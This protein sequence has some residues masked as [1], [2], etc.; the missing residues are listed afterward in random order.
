RQ[1]RWTG[2]HDGRVCRPA[3]TRGPET[4]ANDL[5]WAR[6]SGDGASPHRGA[7]RLVVG[8]PAKARGLATTFEGATAAISAISF[9]RM[10]SPKLSK[11]FAAITNAPGPPTTFCS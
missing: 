4:D 7:N 3:G 6:R 5:A 9:F 10:A 11:S 2:T 1:C 8:P